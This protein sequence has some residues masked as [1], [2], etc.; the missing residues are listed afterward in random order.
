MLV[1]TRKP[2][3]EI[4]IGSGIRITVV[5]VT[6]NKVRLGVVAPPSVLVDRAEVAE[7]RQREGS[8][9]CEVDTLPVHEPFVPESVRV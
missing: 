6:G 2:G 8:S 4:V 7:R 5:A 1:L 9:L 3:E